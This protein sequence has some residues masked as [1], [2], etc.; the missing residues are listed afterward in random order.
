MRAEKWVQGDPE[1][2][3]RDDP[4]ESKRQVQSEEKERSREAGRRL[5]YRANPVAWQAVNQCQEA[6]KKKGPEAS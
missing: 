1:K 5:S 2:A 6:R 3:C 4:C